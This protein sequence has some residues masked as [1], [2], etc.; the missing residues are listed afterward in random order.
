MVSQVHARQQ[1]RL[2]QANRRW[3]LCLTD[4]IH[5]MDESGY[6]LHK[7]AEMFVR[8]QVNL[9]LICLGCGTR[10]GQRRIAEDFVALIKE[11]SS[12]LTTPLDA[13]LLLSPEA[14]EVK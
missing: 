2:R 13:I 6:D 10:S 12:N 1:M 14:E 3:V 9:I 8:H 4:T 11:L 7:V 5:E